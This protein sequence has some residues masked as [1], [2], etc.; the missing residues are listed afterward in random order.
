MREEGVER[1]WG[2][3]TPEASLSSSVLRGS[4]TLYSGKWT[5]KPDCPGLNPSS[6]TLEI[7]DRG[8]VP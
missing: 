7:Y 5:L 8:Q 3:V 4:L 1:H 6:A 2:Y